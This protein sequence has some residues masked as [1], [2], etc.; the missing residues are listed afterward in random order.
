MNRP[1]LYELRDLIARHVSVSGEPLATLPNVVL[2]FEPAPTPPCVY[3]AQPVFSLVAQ[4]IKRVVAGDI[5]LTYGPGQGLTVPIDLPMDAYVLNASEDAPFLGFGLRLHPPAI[6]ALLLEQP[7]ARPPAPTA[8]AKS[9]GVVVSDVDD[10][11]LDA[12][13][14]L[15][16]LLDSPWDLAVLAPAIEREI[17]WRL[18]NTPQGNA[19]RQIGM[20]DS[21]TTKISRAVKWLC[22]H[23]AEPLR[24][25]ALA[26]IA[27]MSETSFHRHFRLVTAMTPI[28][29]QKQL[30]LHAARSRLMSA[31]EDVAQIAFAVGYD[32]PSQF[33]REYRHRYGAPPGKDGRALR[34]AGTMPQNSP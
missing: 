29:Y 10:I 11:L 17:L 14:R 23:F 6:A 31:T 12:I 24:V 13:L 32:S 2:G 28:Q 33:S 8:A 27:G 18:L 21:Q 5:A 15:L 20:A 4:G 34:A 7:I 9:A 25:K 30:R 1:L 19:I 26:D 3:I 16:R 22:L